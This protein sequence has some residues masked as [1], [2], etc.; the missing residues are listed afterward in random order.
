MLFI[1]LLRHECY[2]LLFLFLLL[3]RLMD[4]ILQDS[5]CITSVIHESHYDDDDDDDDGYYSVY[6][7]P[8]LRA[9][10]QYIIGQIEDTRKTRS[11]P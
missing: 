7:S 6:E 2:F 10:F 4:K 11:K 5:R 1:T 9:L 8:F 3:L